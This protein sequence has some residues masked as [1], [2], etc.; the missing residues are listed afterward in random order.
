MSNASAAP[1]EYRP[2]ARQP[3]WAASSPA[4]ASPWPD[5][6]ATPGVVFIA[7]GDD[8]LLSFRTPIAGAERALLR[9]AAGVHGGTGASAADISWEATEFGVR[10]T[11]VAREDGLRFEAPLACLDRRGRGWE[12]DA[13]I[14]ATANERLAT[15]HLWPVEVDRPLLLSP[16]GGPFWVD[17]RRVL[18][19]RATEASEISRSDTWSVGLPRDRRVE[20]SLTIAWPQVSDGDTYPTHDGQRQAWRVITPSDLDA[21]AAT[22]PGPLMVGLHGACNAADNWLYF[23]HPLWSASAKVIAAM[24]LGCPLIVPNFNNASSVAANPSERPLPAGGGPTSEAYVWDAVAEAGRRFAIEPT[25]IYLLGASLGGIMALGISA[26]NPD[27]VA[28]VA[29]ANP[30]VDPVAICAWAETQDPPHGILTELSDALGG[31][32]SDAPLAFQQHSPLWLAPNLANTHVFVRGSRGDDLVAGDVHAGALAAALASFG[33]THDVSVTPTGSHG[34]YETIEGAYDAALPVLCARPRV[35][36]SPD[37]IAYRTTDLRWGSVH[38]IT[39]TQFG[40]PMASVEARRD[41]AD[42]CLHLETTGVAALEIDVDRA[43]LK[44]DTLE[45]ATTCDMDL[46]VTLISGRRRRVIVCPANALAPA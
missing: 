16:D 31:P 5:P 39:L 4:P 11:I 7:E 1:T 26:R 43:G 20:V 15:I 24:V 29:A 42:K 27:R 38:W 14:H 37:R 34:D 28:L 45:L 32:P 19:L 33:A 25:E 10:C 17:F 40:A 36:P 35:D 8:R 30:I 22:G 2:P 23:S 6:W 41:A 44:F 18:V 21:A 12:N 3:S 9:F 13:V 46:E